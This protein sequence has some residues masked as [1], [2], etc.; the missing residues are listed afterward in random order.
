[1]PLAS[2]GSSH[3]ATGLCTQDRHS[4]GGPP[5]GFRVQGLGFRGPP[6]QWYDRNIR[7]PSYN[8]NY[9][10]LP[11]L[12]GVGV[13]LRHSVQGTSSETLPFVV[14]LLRASSASKAE[15]ALEA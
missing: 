7:G 2:L 1:M 10:L 14:L 15:E 9:P 4:L 6:H 8:P 12:L 3:P 5:L 11:L 13:H